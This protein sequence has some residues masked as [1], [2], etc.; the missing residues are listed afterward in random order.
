MTTK[1]RRVLGSAWAKRARTARSRPVD[2]RAGFTVVELLVVSV[3]G[4]VVLGAVFQTLSIQNRTFQRQS[5]TMAA[6]EASRTT[7]AVLSGELRE[8]SSTG[9]DLV[10]ATSNIV[11]MRVLRKFG[12][13]CNAGPA[14]TV[15][16]WELGQ[17]YA[18]GDSVFVFSQGADLVDPDDDAW[19]VGE[20]TSVIKGVGPAGCGITW[21]KETLSG[22]PDGDYDVATISVSSAVPFSDV[23]RGAPV[24]SFERVVYFRWEL[25]SEAVLAR[26]TPVDGV[27][28]LVGSLAP[29]GVGLKFEYFDADGA[30]LGSGGGALAAA[31][32]EEVSFFTTTIKAP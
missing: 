32:L 25:G 19:L 16:V 10:A 23:G 3:L 4:A 13:V 8:V 27:I 20:V 18:V 7:L 9:Q 28:P 21:P 14:G 29:G 26:W 22:M 30:Q 2:G 31:E 15:S 17:P 6:Q 12:F 24:R 5:A 11:I 1:L